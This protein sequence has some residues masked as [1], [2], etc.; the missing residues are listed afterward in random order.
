MNN[1]P[2]FYLI[3]APDYEAL[4]ARLARIEALLE[5][6]RPSQPQPVKLATWAAQAGITPA[7]A[8]RMARAGNMPEGWRAEK[9]GRAW[10]VQKTITI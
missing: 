1:T 8:R 2:T 5:S 10:W 4:Q 9:V 3:P 6:R 7:E